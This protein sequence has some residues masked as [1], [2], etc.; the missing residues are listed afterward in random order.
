MGQLPLVDPSEPPSEQVD[1]VH[2]GIQEGDKEALTYSGVFIESIENGVSAGW[3]KH[4]RPI[5]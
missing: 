5:L 4:I 1:V 2:F 3:E